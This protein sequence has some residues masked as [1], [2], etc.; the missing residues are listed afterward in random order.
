MPIF[1]VGMTPPTLTWNPCSAGSER[2]FVLRPRVSRVLNLWWWAL[3]GAAAAGIVAVPVSWPVRCLLLAALGGHWLRLAPV[4]SP[5]L[6]GS[7]NRT[8]A[9]PELGRN[10]LRLV[11]GTRYASWW[12]RLILHDEQGTLKVLLLRDQFRAQDWRALQAAFYYIRASG[13]KP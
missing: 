2:T 9:A 7:P 5:V 10:A 3:H 1:S 12:I 4:L 11:S 8:W 13:D 6:V